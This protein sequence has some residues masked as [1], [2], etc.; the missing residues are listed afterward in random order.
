MPGLLSVSYLKGCM[1][2]S[3]WLICLCVHL[4]MMF[5]SVPVSV[6]VLISV[7]QMDFEPF[8]LLGARLDTFVNY[9]AKLSAIQ[10]LRFLS[11]K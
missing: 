8:K 6:Q 4:Y 9:F 5:A 3:L 11:F 7:T 1:L 2:Q 10:W